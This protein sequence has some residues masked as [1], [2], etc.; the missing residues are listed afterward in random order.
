MVPSGI[1]REKLLL[2]ADKLEGGAKWLNE[3]AQTQEASFV[4]DPKSVAAAERMI[5]VSV[6][7]CLNIGNHVIAGLR[8]PRADSYVDVFARLVEAGVIEHEM[9]DRMKAA[10]RFRNRVVHV[11][12]D[13][14]PGEVHAFCVTMGPVLTSFLQAVVAHLRSRGFLAGQ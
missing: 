13:V 9:G 14:E 6:E 12:L 3:V 5:Q 11:Y 10:A 7:C 8:L 1:D 4:A 2:Q